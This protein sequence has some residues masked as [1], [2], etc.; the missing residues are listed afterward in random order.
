MLTGARV[1]LR[2]PTKDDLDWL[3]VELNKPLARGQWSSFV[4]RSPVDLERDLFE[5]A[6][7]GAGDLVIEDR[8]GKRLG[9]ASWQGL[10]AVARSAVIEVSLFDPADRGKGFGLDAHRILV[11]HLVRHLGFHRVE[12]LTAVENIPEQKLLEKLRFQREGT[13]RKARFAQGA[14][15]D[16]HL[17]AILEEEWH[18][19]HFDQL[20]F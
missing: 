2:V 19:L 1:L 10:D 16:L 11:D 9:L 3:A 18:D 7:G 4:L 12:V 14:W 20:G 8:H 6:G 13:L 15:H 5:R 17:Y